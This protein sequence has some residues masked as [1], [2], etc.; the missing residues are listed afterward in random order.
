MQENLKLDFKL[1]AILENSIDKE[2]GYLKMSKKITIP[3]LQPVFHTRYL[4]SNHH[5]LELKKC[6]LDTYVFSGDKS[7]LEELSYKKWMNANS[8]LKI[9]D[10]K[11]II[12]QII[13]AEQDC[14]NDYTAMLDN[15][16]LTENMRAL[17]IKQKEI[18]L[19]SLEELKKL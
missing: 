5:T 3:E 1:D 9:A 8:I 14:L 16:K 17:F 6:F 15:Y 19:N 11:E 4:E 10:K 12:A 7:P 2:I 18:I 13:V